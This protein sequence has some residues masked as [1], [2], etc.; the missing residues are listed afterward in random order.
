MTTN[1]LYKHRDTKIQSS[2]LKA[3]VPLYLC[4]SFDLL[5]GVA[6]L[7]FFGL[8][9]PHHLH[10]QE[11]YQL[12]L[13]DSTYAWEIIKQPGGTADLLGRVCTQFFL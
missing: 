12:F 5:F 11:Q 8:A 9:Y 4:V 6:V 13:F 7:L 10:Y 3:S 2:F 1:N